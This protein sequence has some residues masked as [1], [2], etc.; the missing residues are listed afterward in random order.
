MTEQSGPSEDEA[1]QEN[2][3]EDKVVLVGSN[4]T[5]SQLEEHT[6]NSESTGL[7]EEPELEEPD[8]QP[9]DRTQYDRLDEEQNVAPLDVDD[10]TLVLDVNASEDDHASQP[11]APDLGD[12]RFHQLETL[13]VLG[14]LHGW[15]PGLITYLIEHDLATIEVNGLSLGVGGSI[16]A[17]AMMNVFARDSTMNAS[18]LPPAGLA[19]RPRFEE[20]V[21]G[22]G[23]SNVR[24]RWVGGNKIGFIQ[25]GDVIDRSDH[26]ELACE[27]LRQLIL[28][29]PSNVLS[30]I[31][32]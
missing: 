16:D 17:R 22:L 5:D 15:A 14:D 2:S 24:A 13:H 3:V 1:S 32:I 7:P 11:D 28:D 8:V 23:H 6:L 30:L 18:E 10:D 19:G 21:N 26:S 31:H 29:A 4:E 20:V 25:L 9:P 12:H 27:I